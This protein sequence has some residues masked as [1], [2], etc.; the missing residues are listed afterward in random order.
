MKG[1]LFLA[2]G[3]GKKDSTEID[4]LFSREVGKILYIPIAINTDKYSF[5]SCLTFLK[6]C[7]TDV[8]ITMVTDLSKL[9][10]MKLEEFDGIY[11]GGGDTVKLLR[12][13][14][15]ISFFHKLKDFYINGGHIYGGSAGAIILGKSIVSAEKGAADFSSDIVGAKL[16][17]A[18]IWPHY[19]Q[20][21]DEKILALGQQVFAIPDDGGIVI[22]DEIELLGDSHIF[23]ENSYFSKDADFY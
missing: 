8:E 10:H 14:K 19:S 6:S 11:I 9:E 5:D 18:I 7:L 22:A 15:S 21:D 4:K 23:D 1:K 2:G 16:I 3:G 12:D 17:D 13:L 20:E